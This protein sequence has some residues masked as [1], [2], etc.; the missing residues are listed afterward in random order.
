MRLMCAVD[1]AEPPPSFHHIQLAVQMTFFE[2]F[3]GK[4]VLLSTVFHTR[5]GD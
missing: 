3:S 4:Q 5:E 1:G 2:S